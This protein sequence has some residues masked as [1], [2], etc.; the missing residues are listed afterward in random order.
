MT[1]QK[2]IL[3]ANTDWYLYNFRLALARLLRGQGYEVVL[4]SPSGRYALLLQQAGFRWIEWKVGRKSLAPWSELRSI[5]QLARLYRREKPALVHHHTIKPVLYGSL[6]SRLVGIPAAVNSI[7]GRGYVFLGKD[8][9]ARLIRRLVRPFYRLAFSAPDRVAIFENEVDRQYFLQEGL[10]S[11]GQTQLIEGVGV[12]TERF[13]PASEPGGTPIVILPA[14][15]LWDKGV[16]V[17]AE[18]ARLLFGETPQ[19][20][21]QARVALVGIPD[22]GNPASVDEAVLRQWH[23]EKVVEWWGWQDDMRTIYQSC[24]IVTLPSSGEGI[25]TALLEAAACGKPLV[26][27]DAPGCRDVVQHEV[28]GLLVPPNDPAA[29]CAALQRLIADPG[30]RARMGAASRKLVLEKFTIEQINAA[31]LQVVQTVFKNAI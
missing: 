29:L 30:L 11:A 7:T 17:L 8:R 14:R 5:Y 31:T 3:V 20:A 18:A 21:R 23:A 9:K 24:H 1:S 19:D 4:V 27:T 6:A 15:M 16:G 26:A 28:N 10:L 2:I 25:P 22:P 12:D 13:L